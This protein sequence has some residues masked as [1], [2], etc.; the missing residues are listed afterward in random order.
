MKT[1]KTLSVAAF[2]SLEIVCGATAQTNN[3]QQNT[4]VQK[5]ASVNTTMHTAEIKTTSGTNSNVGTTNQPN[6]PISQAIQP[7]N[8]TTNV[9]L[10]RRTNMYKTVVMDKDQVKRYETDYDTNMALW[11]KNNPNKEMSNTELSE[12]NNRT[13]KPILNDEQ[14]T[15]YQQWETGYPQN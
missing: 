9:Q 10:E 7:N 13:L 5:A 12:Y 8:N 11:R 3:T 15:N 6:D 2:L 1:L 4:G 14:Y